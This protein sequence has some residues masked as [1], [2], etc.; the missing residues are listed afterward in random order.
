MEGVAG[1]DLKHGGYMEFIT[2]GR[3]Q[4][5]SSMTRKL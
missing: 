2:E 5:L 1:G 3:E 4:L